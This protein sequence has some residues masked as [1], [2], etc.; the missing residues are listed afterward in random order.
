MGNQVKGIALLK[1]QFAGNGFSPSLVKNNGHLYLWVNDESS[2]GPQRWDIKGLE[3]IHEI[4]G[5]GQLNST[6]Q[7][8]H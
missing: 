1:G 7:L 6:I 5:L 2:N 4:I 3:S 8:D